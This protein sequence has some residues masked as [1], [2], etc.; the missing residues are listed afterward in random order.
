MNSMTHKLAVLA[1]LFC[2]VLA[3]A[4]TGAGKVHAAWE[5]EWKKTVEA[6]K[7][8]GKVTV[9]TSSNQ[10]T[11]L[12]E[13]GAF[14][15]RF[16]EI[17]VIVVFGDPYQRILTERRAGQYL[18]DVGLTG[19]DTLWDLYLARVLDPV[20]DT[21]ILPEV[22]DESKWF[23]GKHHYID[24]EQKY[25]FS[26]IGN[27][28]LGSIFYNAKLINPNEFKSMWDFLRPEWKG[29]ITARDIRSPGPGGVT[30]RFYYYV[31]ELG[32]NFIR[33]LFSEMDITLFR[34][35][36][37][38]IDWLATGKYPLC[39]FCNHTR[40]E[41]ARSQGLP[42]ESFGLMKEGAG[43][44]ASGGAISLVNRAP[45]P[46]A[47]K[48]LI[49]WY[50]SREGQM[51]MQSVGGGSAN[52]RRMDVPKDMVPP[53]RRLQDGVRYVEVETAERMSMEPVLNLYNAALAEAE[54]R[55]KK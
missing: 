50:L 7:N 43:L 29:K 5:A 41:Q 42:V 23:R 38:G 22:A 13:S 10:N 16:P 34:D 6:A 48:V 31:P 36:R 40:I 18:A 1:L 32:P 20:R 19:P 12:F 25:L 53:R 11:L 15:K 44:I 27:A 17:K 47:A 26:A 24:S 46:N 28:D 3:L 37:Q 9:Y 2:L 30:V 14:Q 52:S 35:Q 8:E 45:H 33:R 54:K 51:A 49:N 4:L 21:I 39:L 55:R